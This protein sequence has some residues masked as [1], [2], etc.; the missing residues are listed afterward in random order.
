MKTKKGFLTTQEVVRIFQEK[1][2]PI[3]DFIEA[4]KS[5][6]IEPHWNDGNPIDFED[7][8]I[9]LSEIEKAQKEH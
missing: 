8:E 4:V 5:G 9:V 1:G 7:F 6:E 3:Q 2:I